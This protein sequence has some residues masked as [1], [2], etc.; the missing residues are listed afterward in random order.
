LE[1]FNDR[2]VEMVSCQDVRNISASTS[3]MIVHYAKV[4][5]QTY[6]TAGLF[7]LRLRYVTVVLVGVLLFAVVFIS[8][9]ASPPPSVQQSAAN[10]GLVVTYIS[11]TPGTL[12]L[13]DK[14]VIKLHVDDDHCN[15][16]HN[17]NGNGNGANWNNNDEDCRPEEYEPHHHHGARHIRFASFTLTSLTTGQSREYSN[18][19]LTP[20][21]SDG[22]Y[23]AEIQ[24]DE[25]SPTGS[26]WVY[27]KAGSLQTSV[28]HLV[29]AGPS[30]DTSSEQ[31]EDT[32]GFSQVQVEISAS[33]RFPTTLAL[34]IVAP[35][36]LATFIVLAYAVIRRT[37]KPAEN[38]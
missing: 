5:F 30:I 26:V 21:P 34:S 18:I 7:M 9:R 1:L 12:H 38:Q 28:G 32:S 35:A 4:S 3:S 27:V 10:S 6:T 22:D 2:N 16:D 20:G 31:T 11:T 36:F 29:L 8:A 33:A 14:L 19:P 23:T 13:G 37:R 25:S 15:K 24:I 17:N